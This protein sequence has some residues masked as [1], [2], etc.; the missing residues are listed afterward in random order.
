MSCIPINGLKCNEWSFLVLQ[1]V[2]QIW[3][4]EASCLFFESILTT[5]KLSIVFRGSWVNIENWLE[6]KIEPS[7][8]NLAGPNL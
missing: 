6:P 5:F 1:S 7:L 8:G 4:N 3:I 2:S